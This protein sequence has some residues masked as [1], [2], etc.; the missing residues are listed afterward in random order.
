MVGVKIFSIPIVI[1][2]C[3]NLMLGTRWKIFKG[4]IIRNFSLLFFPIAAG[5]LFL[6]QRHFPIPPVNILIPGIWLVIRSFGLFVGLFIC[7][8]S[9]NY[10]LYN[11]QKLNHYNVDNE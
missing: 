10:F 9:L 4:G 6:I 8:D 5:L 11:Y 3:I 7:H 1:F 2:R